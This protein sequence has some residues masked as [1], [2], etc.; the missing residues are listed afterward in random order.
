MS[1]NVQVL[2]SPAAGERRTQ[3]HSPLHDPDSEDGPSASRPCHHIACLAIA[4]VGSRNIDHLSSLVAY[5]HNLATSRN[6]SLVI[7]AAELR[8]H[9]TSAV[10]DEIDLPGADARPRGFQNVTKHS[11]LESNTILKTLG[12]EPW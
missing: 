12:H 2:D 1:D 5:H 3:L 7:H 11:A 8:C 4:V 10:D 9:E 6:D